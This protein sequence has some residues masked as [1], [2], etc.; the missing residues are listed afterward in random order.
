[1]CCANFAPPPSWGKNVPAADPHSR[2][3]FAHVS[4]VVTNCQAR[5]VAWGVN[6]FDLKG[7]S[8]HSEETA[9][10][11]FVELV[12]RNALPRRWLRKGVHLVNVALTRTYQL[13][14]SRPCRRCSHLIERYS[15]WITQVT[16]TDAAGECCSLPAS[17]VVPGSKTSRGDASLT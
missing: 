5:V 12:Q 9:W 8:V 16:W 13:R 1:M 4:F 3:P 7:Q 10:S 17:Q 15:H 11:K 2:L 14:M 6:G